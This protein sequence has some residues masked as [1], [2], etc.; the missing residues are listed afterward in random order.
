LVQPEFAGDPGFY[1]VPKD[2]ETPEFKGDPGFYELPEPDRVSDDERGQPIEQAPEPP[3]TYYE[4]ILRKHKDTPFVKRMFDVEAP[5]VDKGDGWISTHML[6]T[7][8][9]DGRYY[10]YP[11]IQMGNA[12]TLQD[13][14]ETKDH[15]F[16]KALREGN[17]IEF[18]NPDEALNFSINYK[19]GT[20]AYKKDLFTQKNEQILSAYEARG[21]S[22]AESRKA[23]KNFFNMFEKLFGVV[24]SPATHYIGLSQHLTPEAYAQLTEEEKIYVSGEGFKLGLDML[25]ARLFMPK[26]MMPKGTFLGMLVGMKGVKTSRVALR[27]ALTRAW[28]DGRRTKD[29]IQELMRYHAM[30]SPE[31]KKK[32]AKAQAMHKAGKSSEEQRQATNFWRSEGESARQG[33]DVWKGEISSKDM[34]PRKSRGHLSPREEVYLADYVDHP[35]YEILYPDEFY[36][37]KVRFDPT[38]TTSEAGVIGERAMKI[39]TQGKTEDDVFKSITHEL[40]GHVTQKKEFLSRGGAAGELM[41]VEETMIRQDIAAGILDPMT[42]KQIAKQAS[43]NAIKKYK[44]HHAEAEARG[45]SESAHMTDE[46]L[47]AAG[48]PITRD[49]QY[50]A[51]RPNKELIRRSHGGAHLLNMEDVARSKSELRKLYKAKH[52]EIDDEGIDALIEESA[53]TGFHQ[54]YPRTRQEYIDKIRELD[55]EL[56]DEMFGKVDDAIQEVIDMP[57]IESPI[58]G[59]RLTAFRVKPG[60]MYEW[61]SGYSKYRPEKMEIRG[62]V[63]SLKG[64]KIR[65]GKLTYVPWKK[66]GDETVTHQG[67]I[68]EAFNP[69]TRQWEWIDTA[70]NWQEA[71]SQL[72]RWNQSL[73]NS[74]KENRTQRAVEAM[75]AEKLKFEKETKIGKYIEDADLIDYDLDVSDKGLSK[76]LTNEEIIESIAMSKEVK[77]EVR[78]TAR[79]AGKKPAKFPPSERRG[80]K[81]QKL[82]VIEGRKMKKMKPADRGRELTKKEA[83][84]MDVLND[85][86]EWF[87]R[88]DLGTGLTK[89]EKKQMFKLMDKA[90]EIALNAGW[91]EI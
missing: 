44:S 28:H 79:K 59:G 84:R 3:D 9:Q 47:R 22:H 77:K 11:T 30:R 89:K 41:E 61:Q 40:E 42:D 62:E 43:R 2:L 36:N 69:K 50:H 8:E 68:I 13:L 73:K 83:K 54:P 65:E 20:K 48:K 24:A 19:K 78:R 81:H 35:Q 12:K 66:L 39:G 45:L 90:H 71:G 10:A 38:T 33:T 14:S 34:R 58:H 63:R 56:A 6:A 27:D 1:D 21:Y 60:G 52:P 29:E 26:S 88:K 67:Y 31:L 53:R 49:P 17:V 70:Q 16:G 80:L 76:E 72:K 15:G 4:G 57:F 91:F 37:I 64:E 23:L 82:E 7:A 74:V 85:Q 51:R 5:S 46:E 87:M 25:G 32:L 86:I 18:D 55:P 75:R